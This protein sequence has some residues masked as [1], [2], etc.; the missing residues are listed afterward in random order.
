MTSEVSS[1]SVRNLNSSPIAVRRFEVKQTAGFDWL[2]NL[3]F[4]PLFDDSKWDKLPF[5]SAPV[6]LRGNTNGHD[7]PK[8]LSQPEP[9]YNKIRAVPSERVRIYS[10]S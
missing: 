10:S 5:R 7:S 4:V 6:H 8:T 2:R 3:L 9:H 1:L